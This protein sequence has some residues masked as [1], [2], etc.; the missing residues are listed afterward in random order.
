MK[1]PIVKAFA[2]ARGGRKQTGGFR[3]R[4]TVRQTSRKAKGFG[5]YRPIVALDNVV[6][7]FPNQTLP[8]APHRRIWPRVVVRPSQSAVRT[9]HTFESAGR[10]RPGDTVQVPESANTARSHERGKE[11]SCCASAQAGVEAKRP[12]HHLR[13]NRKHSARAV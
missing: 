5:S 12:P 2:T 7:R 4:R 13:S 6:Q 10:R 11:S 9:C 8:G 3:V 1:L